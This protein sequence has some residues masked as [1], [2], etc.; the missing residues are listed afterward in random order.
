[1]FALGGVM[2]ET[3][4]AVLERVAPEDVAA[5]LCDF[6]FDEKLLLFR[7]LPS[8]EDQ[9]VVLE[10]TDQKSHREILEALSEDERHEIIGEMPVDDLVDHIENLP[11]AEQKRIIASLEKDE[12]E[13]VEEL[14][15]YDPDTA[16]GMM[17]TEFITIPVGTSSGDVLKKI[18]G[19]LGAEAEIIAWLYVTENGEKLRGVVSIRDVLRASPQTVVDDYM[20]TD[21]VKVRVDTDREEVAAVLDKYD[22]PVVPVVDEEDSIRGVATFDDVIDAMQEEHSEDMLRMAGTTSV[23]PLY[24]PILPVMGKR[25]PFLLVTWIGGLCVAT[26]LNRFGEPL[27]GSELFLHMIIWVHLVSALSGNVAVVTSTVLVRG[28]ATGE[29]GLTRFKRVLIREMSVAC[30]IAMILAV[31]SGVSMYFFGFFV[32][33]PG[34]KAGQV[35]L[36]LVVAMS[37]SV[38]WAGLIG[39]LVP[40]V[41]HISRK[42]DPAIASGPFVTITCDISASFIFLLIIYFMIDSWPV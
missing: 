35:I 10:E 31:C 3:L 42:I 36:T 1:M 5:V 30:L 29:V 26:I 4:A 20:E 38:T 33:E 18:Q 32:D 12:A 11:E 37:V 17:T 13:D 2:H 41:C 28:L 39:G 40:V 9:G 15:G 25:L 8:A 21:V 27:V 34:Y 23:H 7:A 6:D 16:G 19:N 14:L 24:E 22:F